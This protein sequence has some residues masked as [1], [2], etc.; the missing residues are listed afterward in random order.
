REVKE[1]WCYELYN[2]NKNIARNKYIAEYREYFKSYEEAL[3]KAL[4]YSL[5]TIKQKTMNKEK[6]ENPK[7]T[8][9]NFVNWY[10]KTGNDQEQKMLL[11]D[12]SNG[13]VEGLATKGEFSLNLETIFNNCDRRGIPCSL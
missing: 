11:K 12:V 4:F 8:R 3:E 9:K 7:I 2:I 6:I 1:T 13:I 10:F 5:K